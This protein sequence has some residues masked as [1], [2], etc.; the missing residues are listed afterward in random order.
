MDEG[1]SQG[2]TRALKLMQSIKT[3]KNTSSHEFSE[4]DLLLLLK[5]KNFKMP[6]E[7][8]V[9]EDILIQ[10]DNKEGSWS[11]MDYSRSKSVAVHRH[12]NDKESE[13]LCDTLLIDYSMPAIL[14][15]APN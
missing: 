6:T 5:D 1:Y 13:C 4:S 14:G 8:R 2:A 12:K 10:G 15:A 3:L 9:D 7:S 11:Q